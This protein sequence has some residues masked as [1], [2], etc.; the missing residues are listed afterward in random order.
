M[1]TNEIWP[2]EAL[3][4]RLV[5]VGVP[6]DAHDTGT[7]AEMLPVVRNG[8]RI[9]ALDVDAIAEALIH[10]ISSGI[11]R[12]P[13]QVDG[14]LG[15]EW[16]AHVCQ[17]YRSE[18]DLFELLVAY[19][20]QGLEG[21]EYCVAIAPDEAHRE[22]LRA[23]LEAALPHRALREGLE[24]LTREQ[25]Y[26]DRDG[27]LKSA[28]LIVSQWSEKAQQA[29]HE[30]FGGVR[31]AAQTD[32]V[33]GFDWRA[34]AEYECEAN[35]A[36]ADLRIKAVCAYPLERCNDRHFMDLRNSH[37]QVLVK[38][39]GWWHR[40]D[41]PEARAASAGLTAMQETVA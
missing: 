18:T 15:L 30:G 26:L 41:T 34:L 11:V 37:Q 5:A 29:L 17:F 38:G 7:L 22:A 24:C 13:C 14:L 32:R 28:A 25:W 16:G 10:L 12:V 21:G 8:T 36:T 6:W 3:R 39:N 9:E 35:A 31:C 19:F 40:I 4:H 27:G 1:I 2:R 23:A 33:D 20:G